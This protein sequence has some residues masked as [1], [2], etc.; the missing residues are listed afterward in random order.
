MTRRATPL[1]PWLMYLGGLPFVGLALGLALGPFGHEAQA[2]MQ[3]ALQGY[4]FIIGAFMA[5]TH[6]GQ[7]DSVTE[8]LR[9]FLLVSSNVLA[10]ALWAGLVLLAF[11]PALALSGGVFLLLLAVDYRLLRAG[12][13]EAGYFA[14]RVRITLVVLAGLALAL[15]A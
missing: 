13:L 12:A 7:R 6:W 2:L 5:G 15:W 10:L 8:A 3:E 1:V 4:A 14:H 11:K 9:L